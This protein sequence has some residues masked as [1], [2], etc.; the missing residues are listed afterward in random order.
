MNER[1]QGAT[2]AQD[3]VTNVADHL[4]QLQNNISQYLGEPKSYRS[5]IEQPFIATV[6]DAEMLAKEFIKLQVNSAGQTLFQAMTKQVMSYPNLAKAA[7]HSI[8]LFF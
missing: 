4:S 1:V 5:W 6:E 3:F 7:L 8:I 2:L